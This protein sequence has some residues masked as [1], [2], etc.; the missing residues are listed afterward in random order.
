MKQYI[1]KYQD[2]LNESINSKHILKAV[3]VVG[4]A[5]SGKSS[6]VNPLSETIFNIMNQDDQFERLLLKYLKTKKLDMEKLTDNEKS[7][8]SELRNIAWKITS[9]KANSFLN[10]L[11][12]VIFDIT[13]QDYEIV[14]NLKDS[15]ESIGY[16]VSCVFVEV[17][18]ET[19]LLRNSRRDRRLTDEL[20]KII[21]SKVSG[22]KSRYKELFGEDFYVIENDK[23]IIDKKERFE[24]I[25]E[26]T[27]KIQYKIL[28][29]PIKNKIG[30]G[31][32]R[33]MRERG[34]KYISDFDSGK[35]KKFNLF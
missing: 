12:P 1:L 29:S 8:I 34:Y 31:L 11:S 22:N 10:S 18:L 19:S 33:Y 6:V 20:V 27:R 24:Y 7:F 15:L 2:F 5:G 13:G 25:Q 26:L 30:V 14:A 4:P 35:T 16:D 21:H 32:L 23:N 9:V 3:I 28:N 17:S